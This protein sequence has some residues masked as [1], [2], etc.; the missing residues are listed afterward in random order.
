D[1]AADAI[2]LPIAAGDQAPW[3]LLYGE[4]G[5]GKTTLLDALAQTLE[6][7]GVLALRGR[8]HERELV[9][10]KGFDEIVD[11]LV[12]H[13]RRLRPQ[14]VTALL[15]RHVDALTRMFPV[16]GR[17]EPFAR[18]TWHGATAGDPVELRRRGF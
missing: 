3:V 6:A 1:D 7:R 5:I 15:P 13:L 16:L 9:P 17:V 10:F 14:E 2:T 8:C 18:A 11:T 12:R 4:P